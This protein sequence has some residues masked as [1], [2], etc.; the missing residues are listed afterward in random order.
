MSKPIVVL[1]CGSGMKAAMF[2]AAEE[3]SP[4]A[5]VAPSPRYAAAAA[6]R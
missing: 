3:E 6:A 4:M 1:N 2:C 5:Q